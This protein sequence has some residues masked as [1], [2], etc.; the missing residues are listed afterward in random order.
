MRGGLR[1]AA[2]I[3]LG[4][5][6]LASTAAHADVFSEGNIRASFDGW[7]T[8]KALPRTDPVPVEL[9]LRGSLRTTDNGQL[10]VLRRI[11]VSVNRFGRI[12]TAGLPV[13]RKRSI[14]AT[15]TRQALA[16]CGDA[17]VGN[18]RFNA[19]IALPA[20]APFPARGRMLAFHAKVDGRQVILAHI[21]GTDPLPTSQV[22]TMVIK[23]PKGRSAF[24]TILSMTVPK[25]G[26]DDWG[27]VTGFR[28]NLHRRYAY[29]H[30]TRSVISANC[31][32]P[33][34]FDVGVFTAAKATYYLAGGRTISRV[35]T[36]TCRIRNP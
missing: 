35:V 28:M 27:H 14:V 36:G 31:P 18:G 25:V 4:A 9:H 21:Y 22:M 34:G 11:E 23:H 26:N 12:S 20:E 7:L 13:C 5:F 1:R 24:G 6:I 16:A 10:P 15:T 29:K 19:F 2:G 17:L 32:A 30:Q 8:P 3:V 33:K